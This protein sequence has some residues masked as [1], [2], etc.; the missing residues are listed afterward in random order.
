M[1]SPPDPAT[2]QP[3]DERYVQELSTEDRRRLTK[4]S[5][6]LVDL[7]NPSK[8]LSLLTEAVSH[9]IEQAVESWP[10][11]LPKRGRPLRIPP[12]EI[13]VSRG[14][15]I[16]VVR[17]ELLVPSDRRGNATGELRDLGFAEEDTPIP[18]IVRFRPSAGRRPDLPDAVRAL[19]ARNLGSAHH[20]VA[21]RG[22]AKSADGP[23]YT[24][25]PPDPQLFDS[26][27]GTGALV[28]VIDT[29]IDP[30]ASERKDQWLHDMAQEDV[31]PLDVFNETTGAV[32]SDTFLDGAAGHGTFIAG[33][34][35]QFAPQA[36]V[37]M[38]RALDSRGLGTEL[39]VARAIRD[40]AGMFGATGGVL[41]LSLGFETV[42]GEEPESLR[43]AL[44]ALPDSV[45]VAAAAG[46]EPGIEPMWPASFNDLDF[47][48]GVA[49][50][51]WDDNM[52]LVKNDWSNFG[53]H[54]DF[55]AV[56]DVSSTYVIGREHPA[57]DSNPEAFPR[58]F[59][60]ADGVAE[61]SDSYALWSGTSFSTPK[62]AAML[63]KLLA[64]YGGD[65]TAAL[66]A[67]RA[68][69]MNNNDGYGYIVRC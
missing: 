31:D 55:S 47:V 30:Y 9:R 4:L 44:E 56:G 38:I 49:A 15:P 54:V 16:P 45:L 7:Q 42:D 35:R 68:N 36:T 43:L 63:A 2:W 17:D 58:P 34:V 23:E 6:Q 41:N 20:I 12:I 1:S 69:R 11:D 28:V 32:R 52:D 33:I 50:L 59:S 64:E 21:L 14:R 60:A 40:A 5:S 57:R 3:D 19:R 48:L 62:V 27:R 66:T 10:A 24:D 29:G 61:Q 39:D 65:R 67:M 37:R 18:G 13:L 53:D 46:N 26:D 22:P 25:T 8:Q 51:S